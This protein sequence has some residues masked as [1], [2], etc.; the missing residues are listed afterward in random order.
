MENRQDLPQE[1]EKNMEEYMDMD[2]DMDI[3]GYRYIYFFLFMDMDMDMDI[4]MDGWKA[5]YE[6]DIRK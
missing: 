2:M 6:E 5:K 1:R 4:D 3:Y